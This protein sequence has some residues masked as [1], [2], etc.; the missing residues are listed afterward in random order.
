MRIGVHPALLLGDEALDDRAHLALVEQLRAAAQRAGEQ[1]VAP[2]VE[3]LDPGAQAGQ[4]GGHLLLRLLVVGEGEHGLALVAAVGEQVAQPLGEH[5]GLARA[6]R[7]HDAGR[8]RRR[9]R[10][11]ASW[12]GASDGRRA[13]PARAAAWSGPSSTVSRWTTAAPSS[14]TASGARGPPSIQAGV[15]S[16]RTTSPGPPARPAG[17]QPDRLA[18]PPPDRLAGGLGV[19]AVGPH[20]EVEAVGPRLEPGAQPPRLV[21]VGRR[22]RGSRPGSTASSMTTGSRSLQAACRRATTSA[23]SASAAS[24]TTTRSAA[25][26]GSGARPPAPTRTARPSSGVRQRPEA[27]LVRV[28]QHRRPRRSRLT[29]TI[30]TVGVTRHR[31]TRTV[32]PWP[33]D[34]T[35]ALLDQLA[36]STWDDAAPAG[37]RGPHRRGAPLGAGG[38]HVER[39]PPRRRRRR[40]CRPATGELAGRLGLPRARPAA[41]DHHRLA[42]RPHHRRGASACGTTTTSAARR[43]T[44]TTTEWW[45]TA[46]GRPRR[47]RRAATPRWVAG[48][49]AARARGPGAARRPGRGPVRRVALRR[50]GPPHPPRGAPPRRRGPAAAATSTGTG[51]SLGR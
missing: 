10:P 41:H 6:G 28:G 35:D 9:G 17:A 31:R 16:G 43:S 40:R 5:P 19:V 48:V 1:A 26:Q 24:S 11:T 13:R 21:V 23:G 2:R 3:G 20:E 47:A 49:A 22:A 14:G 36:H 45:G 12:S 4:P 8:A 25:A 42:P 37:A 50:A 33:I 15:P 46:D 18:G 29:P 27:T 44:T 7:G 32:E 34:W 51:R 39:P 38:G 30:L